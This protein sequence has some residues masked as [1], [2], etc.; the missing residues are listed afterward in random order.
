MVYY[1]FSAAIMCVYNTRWPGEA[2]TAQV[3]LA[4]CMKALKE[5]EVI[6]GSAARQRELLVGLVDL[7]EAE[8]EIAQEGQP[9]SKTR[10]KRNADTQNDDD[11][12]NLPPQLDFSMAHSPP[13]D[14]STEGREIRRM[15]ST[16]RQPNSNSRASESGSMPFDP[17]RHLS[18]SMPATTFN[19]SAPS[20]AVAIP[21]T[22]N[23]HQGPQH[24]QGEP[25]LSN[26][27]FNDLLTSFLGNA[28]AAPMGGFS[29]SQ[30]EGHIHAGQFGMTSPPPN[31]TNEPYPG[32]RSVGNSP[33]PWMMSNW[34]QSP[35]NEPNEPMNMLSAAALGDHDPSQVH[36][37]QH[38]SDFIDQLKGL[39]PGSSA[40]SLSPK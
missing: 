31:S 8:Q 22:S 24:Q 33:P 29:N 13:F 10:N 26:S 20:S 35:P 27:M 39:S 14:V 32:M 37:M 6:W 12:D 9:G 30:F 34:I 4:K 28:A 15:S 25:Q 36:S 40:L 3:S 7:A 1:V 21:G 11:M 38:T 16:S 2:K 18:T 5:M 19:F 17:I 23:H